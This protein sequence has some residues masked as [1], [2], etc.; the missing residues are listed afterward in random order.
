MSNIENELWQC[1]TNYNK[2]FE[3]VEEKILLEL[4]NPYLAG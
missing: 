3:I 1:I 4:G 2:F